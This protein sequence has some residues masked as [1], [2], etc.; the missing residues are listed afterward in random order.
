MHIRSIQPQREQWLRGGNGV[1]GLR[2][3]PGIEK[4]YALF[5]QLRFDPPSYSMEV[6]PQRDHVEF[7]AHRQH[8]LEMVHADPKS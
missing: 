3:W 1:S 4:A 6:V 5:S 7:L 2:L 8:L